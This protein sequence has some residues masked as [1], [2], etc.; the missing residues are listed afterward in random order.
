[1][2]YQKKKSGQDDNRRD[3]VNRVIDQIRMVEPRMKNIPEA[4]VKTGDYN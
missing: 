2:K 1:M 3:I 4:K